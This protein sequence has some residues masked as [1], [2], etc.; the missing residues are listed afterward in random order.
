MIPS[1]QAASAT[2]LTRSDSNRY[3]WV[4]LLTHPLVLVGIVYF[5]ANGLRFL[6]IHRSE[7]D[8][9][10][11]VAAQRLAAGEEMY[12]ATKLNPHVFSYPPFMALLALPFALLP[13]HL[14]RG[15]WFL[16]NV[17][18]VSLLGCWAWWA[19]GGPPLIGLTLLS[20]AAW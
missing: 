15:V 6:L 1:S 8:E 18:A 13:V 14:E 10:Y 2:N 17:A 5:V 16:I 3:S 19:S 9:V 7:W 11:I 4:T 20:P 12:H